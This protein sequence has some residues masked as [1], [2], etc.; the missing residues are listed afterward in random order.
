MLSQRFLEL[1]NKAAAGR[2]GWEGEGGLGRV[3][4]P[5]GGSGR[6][7]GPTLVGFANT[8]LP[9]DLFELS[10]PA[11]SRGT[12]SLRHKSPISTA[13]SKPEGEPRFAY[14]TF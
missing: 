6:Q 11:P 4:L 5:K 13:A 8:S 1:P 14:S 3:P 10:Y 2:G 9:K 12:Q 7:S